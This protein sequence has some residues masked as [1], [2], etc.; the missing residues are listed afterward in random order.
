M[1]YKRIKSALH[2]LGDSFLGLTNYFHDFQVLPELDELVR[3][4]PDGV[5]INLSTGTI[6]PDAGSARHLRQAVV[7]YRD[8]LA[9]HFHAE[10]V[11]LAVLQDIRVHYKPT[12]EGR[13]FISAV[14]DRGTEH[15]IAL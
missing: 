8:R 5:S 7:A 12:A 6:D 11:D 9:A 2:N 13:G 4:N 14:D 1:K 3:A 10:G 15:R